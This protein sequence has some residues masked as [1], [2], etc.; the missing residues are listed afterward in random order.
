[1]DFELESCGHLADFLEIRYG[2]CSLTYYLTI[3]YNKFEVLD[4]FAGAVCFFFS[5]STRESVNFFYQMFMYKNNHLNMFCNL[6][7]CG[8]RWYL[9][10][11][12][13]FSEQIWHRRARLPYSKGRQGGWLGSRRGVPE[14]N[15]ARNKHKLCCPADCYDSYGSGWASAS[16]PK[17]AAHPDMKM[18]KWTV[19][20][21]HLSFPNIAL[22]PRTRVFN[23]TLVIYDTQ[24]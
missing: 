6:L 7:C 5:F 4:H 22:Y 3:L 21:V 19:T 23:S 17:A 14:S 1:M 12:C 10:I 18:Y 16:P 24:H 13:S 11:V 15:Q 2:R 9:L 8:T 20:L